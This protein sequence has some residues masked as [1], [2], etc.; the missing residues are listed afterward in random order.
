MFIIFQIKLLFTYILGTQIYV[1][2]TYLYIMITNYIIIII[3]I[4]D[5]FKSFFYILIFIHN[6]KYHSH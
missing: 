3:I 4:T 1:I 5:Y 6:L 2:I